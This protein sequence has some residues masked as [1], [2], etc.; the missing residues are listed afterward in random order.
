IMTFENAID[1]GRV[2]TGSSN[3]SRSGLMDNL[4]FN[5]EL[6]NPSDYEF[7]LNKFDELWG[8]AVDVSEEYVQT[9]ETKTWM[10]DTIKPYELYLEFLY[11]YFKEELSSSDDLLFKYIPQDF[12]ELEY[13]RLAVLN[14]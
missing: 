1:K 2:I 5:V 8:E 11:E 3:F 9:L 14:A 7:A 13:Q 12:K 10:N 4:E 6:K